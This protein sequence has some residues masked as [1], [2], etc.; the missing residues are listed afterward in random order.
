MNNGESLDGS[1]ML[2]AMQQLDQRRNQDLRAVMPD[3]ADV[4][5]YRNA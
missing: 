1:A 5:G 3:W 2:A 4:I